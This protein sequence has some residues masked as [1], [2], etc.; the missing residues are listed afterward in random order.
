[1]DKL[2]ETLVSSYPKPV[3]LEDAS[4]VVFRPL[5]KEDEGALAAFFK[6]LPLKDRAC[7][8]EDVSDPLVIASWIEKLDYDAILPVI[9]TDNGRIV[10]DATLHFNPTG[11]TRHQAEIR[12]TTG[13]SHRAKGLGKRLTQD[14]IDIARKLGLEQLSIE[15]APELQ[16]A[17]LLCQK[18]GFKQAAVLKGFI[19]DLDG[20]ERDLVLMI[21]QLVD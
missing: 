2:V 12:L 11:W 18:L 6:D 15:L 16:D 13:V 14:V 21:K 19:V 9:A 1:M 17:F 8:K 4:E 7:L 3:V 5:R 10:G 20:N